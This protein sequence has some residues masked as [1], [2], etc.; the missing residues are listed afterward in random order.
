MGQTSQT[1]S[2]IHIV[3][4]VQVFLDLD[5]CLK[6]ANFRL[7]LN[8]F[9]SYINFGYQNFDYNYEIT[10][11]AELFG[12][13]T[14]TAIL[15]YKQS[16]L[17]GVLGFHIS[18]PGNPGNIMSTIWT[19][20]LGRLWAFFIPDHLKKKDIKVLQTFS[21]TAT[22]PSAAAKWRGRL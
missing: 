21:T 15:R 10:M 5:F 1:S 2:K 13:G 20:E 19:Q 12:L 4:K 17:C 14:G 16:S 11:I 9:L 6:K 3:T 18:A 22:F 7:W 8:F